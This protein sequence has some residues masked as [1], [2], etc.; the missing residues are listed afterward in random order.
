VKSKAL[1]L[2]AGL[3]FGGGLVISG[4]TNPAKVL[5]FLDIAGRW[6]PSL[7]F[8]MIGAIGLHFL[9]LRRILAR[10]KPLL[11][12]RFEQPRRTAIDLPLVAGAALFGVGWGLGGVC[13]GPGIVDAASGSVYAIVFMV[14]MTL[15]TIAA[16][17]SLRPE[18]SSSEP[19]A[20]RSAA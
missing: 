8:V 7:A 3:L 20:R 13:P 19:Q 17:R 12:A 1:A 5:G 9:L 15:G 14:G 16:Q 6:D 4:M 11:E 2:L 18:V 10:P